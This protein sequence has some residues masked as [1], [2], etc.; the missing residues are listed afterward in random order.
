[1]CQ[2]FLA[3]YWTKT[4]RLFFLFFMECWWRVCNRSKLSASGYLS[5][6]IFL[7]T[8]FL[9]VPDPPMGLRGKWSSD[10][11]SSHRVTP[12][13]PFSWKLDVYWFL[14]HQWGFEAN[15]AQIGAPHIGFLL[16]NHFP[17]NSIS[18]GSWPTNGISGQMELRFELPTSSYPL[19]TIFLKTRFLLV[20]SPPMGFR[21]KWSSGSSSPHRITLWEL[22]S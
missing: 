1:M 15:G 6:T 19:E 2:W 5:G 21:G 13:Q 14:A 9:L 7:K 11:N 18:I 17:E 20:P 10:S 3:F 8:R 12:R 22:F 4:V 16:G